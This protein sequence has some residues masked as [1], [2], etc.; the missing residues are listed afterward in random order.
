MNLHGFFKKWCL[1]KVLNAQVGKIAWLMT[2]PTI[3]IFHL[4]NFS[5]KQQPTSWADGMGFWTSPVLP[6]RMQHDSEL[7]DTEAFIAC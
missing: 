3:V 4:P 6:G 2:S 7:F 1:L 5:H